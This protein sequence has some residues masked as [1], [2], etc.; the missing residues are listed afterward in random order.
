MST[1]TGRSSSKRAVWAWLADHLAG[2]TAEE[3]GV[4]LYYDLTSCTGR[5]RR[6]SGVQPLK[7][8]TAWASGLLY[9]LLKDGH[10]VRIEETGEPT[11][12]RA[13]P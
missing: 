9:G 10:A 13:L 3:I 2:A 11:R 8:A 12:W 5:M 6:N 1:K 4:A 7:V